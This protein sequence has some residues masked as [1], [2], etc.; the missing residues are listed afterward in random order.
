MQQSPPGPSGNPLQTASDFEDSGNM[1]MTE[2]PNVLSDMGISPES[3]LANPHSVR[4]IH[5]EPNLIGMDM[6]DDGWGYAQGGVPQSNPH[7][8]LDAQY[9][10]FGETIQGQFGHP[11]SDMMSNTPFPGPQ[12]WPGQGRQQ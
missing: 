7:Y 4:T 12:Q 8:H 1:S 6:N 10:D 11:D 2:S 5:T 9:I 3:F